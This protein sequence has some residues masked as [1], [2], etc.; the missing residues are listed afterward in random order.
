MIDFNVTGMSCQHCVKAVTES[1]RQVDPAAQVNVD[2]ERGRVAI[3]S[4][5]PVAAL[6]AA[7]EDAG[8]TVAA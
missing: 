5:Q 2:L 6:K 3:D 4:T 8:Y 1:I 7:I